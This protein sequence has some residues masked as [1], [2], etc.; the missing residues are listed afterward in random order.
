MSRVKIASPC[1]SHLESLALIMKARRIVEGTQVRSGMII[2]CFASSLLAIV[3]QVYLTGEERRGTYDSSGPGKGR[4]G[5][6]VQV[7]AQKES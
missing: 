3:L 6:T 5:T 7:W 2:F 1:V 4:W